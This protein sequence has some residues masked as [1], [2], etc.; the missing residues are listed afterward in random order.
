MSPQL[1]NRVALSTCSRQCSCAL[2]T[3]CRARFARSA[4][5]RHPQYEDASRRQDAPGPAPPSDVL[6]FVIASTLSTVS[7]GRPFICSYDMV[8]AIAPSFPTTESV[9]SFIGGEGRLAS[10]WAA[11]QTTLTDLK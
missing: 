11:S 9:S 1:D 5:P 2:R 7:P 10:S 8:I 3:T 4:E 6:E